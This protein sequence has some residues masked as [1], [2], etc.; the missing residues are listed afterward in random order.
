MDE[1]LHTRSKIYSRL[2]K[3]T[4]EKVQYKSGERNNLPITK[5]QIEKVSNGFILHQKKYIKQISTIKNDAD[6]TSFKYVSAKLAWR[7]RT[8]PDT[9]CSVQTL[10]KV[11]EKIYTSIK[12]GYI[13]EVLKIRKYLQKEINAV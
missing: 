4:E 10:R 9:C 1:T 6:F 8:R 12:K 13:K 7:T 5:V 2:G 3:T 11:N